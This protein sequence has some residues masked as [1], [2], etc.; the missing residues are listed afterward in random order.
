M[1]LQYKNLVGWQRADDLF[2]E[3]HRITHQCFPPEERYELGRQL[4]RAALS[5]P[6][7]IVEGNTRHHTRDKL[8]FFNIASGSLSEVTYGLHAA[9]RLG[10]ID[11][12]TYQR[13][14]EHA[15]MVTAPLYG[16]IRKKRAELIVKSV[17][18]V[19]TILMFASVV[20]F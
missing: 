4:R 5:V 8:N 16:L 20:L 3:V 15:R 18:S 9:H 6:S 1:S 12:V 14:D 11:D 7:N 13:L 10:Y 17:M 19:T 2:V